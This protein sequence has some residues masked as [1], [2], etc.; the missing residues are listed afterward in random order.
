MTDSTRP[1]NASSATQKLS[2]GSPL[3]AVL[4]SYLQE[5]DEGRAVPPQEMLARHPQLG[6]PLA[7]MLDTIQSLDRQAS[8]RKATPQQPIQLE[9]W[10]IL[11]HLGGG[12]SGVVFEA[13]H[14]AGERVALKLFPRVRSTE[15][16]ARFRREVRVLSRIRHPHVVPHLASG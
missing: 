16:L 4:E 9:G 3:E 6:E 5:L 10:E 8:L 7:E 1:E 11:R 13:R 14:L 12:G 15:A 2:P